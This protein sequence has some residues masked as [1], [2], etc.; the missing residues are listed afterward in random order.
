LY[1]L[2]G[3]GGTGKTFL[4]NCIIDTSRGHNQKTVAV[5]STGVAALLLRGG[6]TAHS[7]FKIP[8]NFSCESYCNFSG[9]DKVGRELVDS[10]LIVWDEA[11]SMHK[12]AIETV[13]ACYYYRVKL[14]YNI[15]II[16][17]R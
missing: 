13:S 6:K 5:A 1:Y 17:S 8:V 16:N 12:N 2:D 14:T 10:D 11:I 3:P 15:S 7:G 9:G 4:L